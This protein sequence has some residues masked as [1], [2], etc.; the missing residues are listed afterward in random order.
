[1]WCLEILLDAT[2]TR[3]VDFA[4]YTGNLKSAFRGMVF[5]CLPWGGPCSRNG[6]SLSLD[7][8]GCRFPKDSVISGAYGG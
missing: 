2:F 6:V 3:E 7:T 5:S 4:R 1:M 8:T